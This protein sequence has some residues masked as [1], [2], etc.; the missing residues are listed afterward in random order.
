MRD[1]IGKFL[2]PGIAVGF[3][4]AMPD[5]EK[6]MSRKLSDLNTTLSREADLSLGKLSAEV[7][8]KTAVQAAKDSDFRAYIANELNIDYDKLGNATAKAIRDAD[9]TLELNN[10]EI[11]RIT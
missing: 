10:R 3:E 6:Q 5:T 11:G 8:Y 2:P 7:E 4:M 9:I 1:M